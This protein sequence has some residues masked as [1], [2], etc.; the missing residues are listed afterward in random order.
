MSDTDNDT[1]T[2][3]EDGIFYRREAL[4]RIAHF[5]LNALERE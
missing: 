2:G 1:D 4:M 3:F 5:A